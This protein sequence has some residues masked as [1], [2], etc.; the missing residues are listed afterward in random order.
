M[1][2]LSYFGENY[3]YGSTGK[4]EYDI[5]TEIDICP[6]AEMGQVVEALIKLLNIATYHTTRESVINAVNDYFD[7]HEW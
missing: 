5:K 6:D 4:Q 2:K 1:I 3:N 7:E